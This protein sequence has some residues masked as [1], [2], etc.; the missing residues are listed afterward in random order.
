MIEIYNSIPEHRRAALEHWLRD[1]VRPHLKPDVSGYARGRLRAW[2]EVEPS[3]TNPVTHR[4]GLPVG[5]ST[6]GLAA[7]RF[8]QLKR[9]QS[10]GFTLDALATLID[11]RFDYCLVTFSGDEQP[12]GIT[13][14]RDARYA[15]FEEWE[16]RF[17]DKPHGSRAVAD[18]CAANAHLAIF[19]EMDAADQIKVWLAESNSLYSETSPFVQA[20]PEKYRGPDAVAAYRA[21]Y[22]AKKRVLL[23]KPAKWT[24][25]PVPTWFGGAQ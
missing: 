25:R 3:L 15:D 13:P 5:S 2:L 19:S 9:R 16:Y 22:A 17:H 6:D 20:M 23:G 7:C 21:Y 14:H 10:P 11:W 4:P 12:I 18:W 8:L 1:Q 24:R